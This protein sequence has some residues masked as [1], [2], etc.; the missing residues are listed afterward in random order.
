MPVKVNV[1]SDMEGTI[2]MAGAAADVAVV[3]ISGMAMSSGGAAVAAGTE[4]GGTMAASVADEGDTGGTM[5][6]AGGAEP[7]PG[8]ASAAAR[9]CG[10][11]CRL[12]AAAKVPRV[13]RDG[14]PAGEP[15]AARPLRDYR[16]HGRP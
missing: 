15:T 9:W 14:L 16:R 6:S 2:G 7:G 1:R 3:F 4:I 13:A 8:A 12:W 11:S 10:R 5:T